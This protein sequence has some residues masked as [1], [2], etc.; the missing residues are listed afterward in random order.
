[1]D[2]SIEF[3]TI[4]IDRIDE[5]D[6]F[7]LMSCR[8]NL[9]TLKESIKRAGITSPLWVLNKGKNK[10]RLI[11]GFLRLKVAKDI[12]LE[13]IPVF[14]FYL[15][16]LNNKND[17]E[18]LF[19]LALEENLTVR[20]F[21]VVEISM[22]INSFFKNFG[23]TKDKIAKEV[24]PRL[25][26]SPS[27]KLVRDLLKLN[28]FPIEVKK[29]IA[30]NE[31]SLK[32]SLKFG[33]F[34]EK[35]QILIVKFLSPLR[36]KENYLLEFLENIKDISLRDNM[37]IKDMLNQEISQIS[38]NED[39]STQKRVEMI[40]EKLKKMKYPIFNDLLKNFNLLK[41]NLKI[42]PEI[43]LLYPPYFEGDFYNITFSFKTKEELIKIIDKLRDISKKEEIEELI[44]LLHG[45]M[46]K[47]SVS[48]N[49]SDPY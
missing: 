32:T 36:L 8:T 30:K 4:N 47:L 45:K 41:K 17:L 44:L 6:K 11:N 37:D 40:R 42:P 39:I 16:D 5:T 18:T 15:R 22:V 20:R 3:K 19:S 9:T 43:K 10:Y 46:R 27:V 12:G 2:E 34:N 48:V 13:K 21:N 7:F 1:M 14:V 24:L 23:V 38:K 26:L 49:E 33:M 31:H 35:E 28:S 29:Y 25:D